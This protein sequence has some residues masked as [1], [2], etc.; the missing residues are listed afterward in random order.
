MNEIRGRDIP[1]KKYIRTESGVE[2]VEEG[3]PEQ[4]EPPRLPKSK[5]WSP[6]IL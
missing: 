4:L 6:I 3:D 5:T 1:V 2:K